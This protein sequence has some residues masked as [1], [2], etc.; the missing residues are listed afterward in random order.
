MRPAKPA[1]HFEEC[2]CQGCNA[3]RDY[4]HPLLQLLF[5]PLMPLMLVAWVAMFAIP[6]AA[7]LVTLYAVFYALSWLLRG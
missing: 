7:F 4:I 5:I 2:H 6:A 1:G 3:H